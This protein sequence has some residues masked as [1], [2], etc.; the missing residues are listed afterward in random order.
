MH[1][2]AK[3]Q[4][5]RG[6]RLTTVQTPAHRAGNSKTSTPSH[7]GSKP[8]RHIG[9]ALVHGRDGLNMRP[10]KHNATVDFVEYERPLRGFGISDGIWGAP[11]NRGLILLFLSPLFS[12]EKC[13]EKARS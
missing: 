5:N 10:D 2:P 9:R 3:P 7:P 8:S 6:N 11:Q 4:T 13:P 12:D 1:N